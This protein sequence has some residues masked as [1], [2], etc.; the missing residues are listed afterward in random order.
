MREGMH[1]PHIERPARVLPESQVA[2]VRRLFE[3]FDRRDRAALVALTDPEIE[4]FAPTALLA[5]EGRCYRGHDGLV[6]YLSDVERLWARLELLP[7]KYREIGNHVVALGRVRAQ[8][9]DGLEVMSPTAWIWK[10]RHGRLAWGCVYSD[11]GET[12]KGISLTDEAP[13]PEAAAT[14]A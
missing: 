10:V 5:N 13:T 14:P 3:A 6:R 1:R 4:F 2:L 9:R 12:F 8:A 11:P 7:E